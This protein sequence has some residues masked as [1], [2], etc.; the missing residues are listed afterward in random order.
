MKNILLL[1]FAACI[2]QCCNSSQGN[3]ASVTLNFVGDRPSEITYN[4]P[5]DGRLYPWFRL[6][7]Q[8]PEEGSMTMEFSMDEPSFVHLIIPDK[9]RWLYRSFVFSPNQNYEIDLIRTDSINEFKLIQDRP[10]VN[11]IL[12]EI[13]MPGLIQLVLSKY[14]D[15]L[16]VV[17]KELLNY[18][19]SRD[20]LK[21]DSLE[22]LISA[23]K[24][25]I[26]LLQ[27]DR[28]AFY[29][30][31]AETII[32]NNSYDEDPLTEKEKQIW[33]TIYTK[34]NIE[35]YSKTRSFGY[36]VEDY[37]RFLMMTK[38]V[39]LDQEKNGPY[40]SSDLNELSSKGEFLEHALT[41][42][43]QWGDSEFSEF[44]NAANV[45]FRLVNHKN[46]YE[47]LNLVDTF[48]VLYPNSKFR[49]FQ[50]KFVDELVNYR[51]ALSE[52]Y[53]EGTNFIR[54]EDE[55]FGF[56]DIVELYKGKR[57]FIDVWAT[58]C[59]S[60]LEDFEYKSR[61]D[62]LLS[63]LEY[64]KLFISVDVEEAIPK[65]EENIKH[66][67]LAGDHLVASQTLK[68]DLAE[69]YKKGGDEY[70][71]PWYI[72]VNEKGEISTLKASRPYEFKKL[73]K[74]LEM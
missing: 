43:S 15:S 12:G 50:E 45:Q 1:L 52:G 40:Q 73:K 58:W 65:W 23:S 11:D 63:E 67:Q 47:Y 16:K 5:V 62:S 31:I 30:T 19:L 3:Y 33:D 55:D 51:D 9:E 70:S 39:K 18:G 21:I 29:S 42:V 56:K 28:Q 61:V 7:E 68:E 48:N 38:E 13:K 24:E 26:R 72:I 41:V 57:I 27:L 49:V 25:E 22:Q 36:L 69:M 46:R 34:E 71:I 4:A 14:R 35:K 44:V 54:I 8:C 59:G 6:N 64:S 2:F 32:R 10:S 20:L 66:Y 37:H 53:T 60:C 74:E 17:N